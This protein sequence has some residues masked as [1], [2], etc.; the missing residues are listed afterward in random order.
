[1]IRQKGSKIKDVKITIRRPK[2]S[3]STENH[4]RYGTLALM[5]SRTLPRLLHWWL[6]QNILKLKEKDKQM[7]EAFFE[8]VCLGDASI[9]LRTP[10]RRPALSYIEIGSNKE[11]VKILENICKFLGL[12]Y[13]K[14]NKQNNPKTK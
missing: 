4:A 13:E 11:H 14:Q 8:G 5:D 12:N 10:P 2:A 7:I 3:K 6:I 9:A 1:M